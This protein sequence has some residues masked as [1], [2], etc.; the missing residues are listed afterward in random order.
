M[1]VH[2]D[3]IWDDE[4]CNQMCDTCHHAKGAN[5]FMFYVFFRDVKKA[6]F[7]LLIGHNLTFVPC[8]LHHSG[9]HR[10]CQAGGANRGN[11]DVN[12]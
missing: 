12:G 3:E 1:A 5:V 9:H 10:A 7:S 2:F 6:V 11:S 8:R 4:G